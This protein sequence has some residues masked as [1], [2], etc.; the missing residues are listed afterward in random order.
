MTET[1]RLPAGRTRGGLHLGV[2]LVSRRDASTVHQVASR[3]SVESLAGGRRKGTGT[4]LGGE[5]VKKAKENG[6]KRKKS[7]TAW[8]VPRPLVLLPLW[9][10]PPSCSLLRA[11]SSQLHF[12]LAP[13]CSGCPLARMSE[14]AG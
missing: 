14:H 5:R 4:W 12:F 13:K 11:V 8:R 2:W 9:P 3:Y 7:R 6:K 10:P 1:S